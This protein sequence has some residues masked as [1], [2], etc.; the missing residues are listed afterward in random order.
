MPG[1]CAI[2]YIALLAG[3]ECHEYFYVHWCIDGF[4]KLWTIHFSGHA[5]QPL[6]VYLRKCFKHFL[7]YNIMFINLRITCIT[8]ISQTNVNVCFWLCH[9]SGST[10]DL[11]QNNPCHCL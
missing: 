6:C 11:T 5:G 1:G 7:R 4:Q 3:S 9:Q 8:F 2:C 10:G